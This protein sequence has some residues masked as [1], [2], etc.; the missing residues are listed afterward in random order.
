M[1]KNL[2][3]G[4]TKDSCMEARAKTGKMGE[5]YTEAGHLSKTPQT[6]IPKKKAG[7]KYRSTQTVDESQQKKQFQG[8]PLRGVEGVQQERA[9]KPERKIESGRKKHGKYVEQVNH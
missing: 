7:E 3:L 9:K 5:I 2:L 4:R 1:K 8:I 6:N